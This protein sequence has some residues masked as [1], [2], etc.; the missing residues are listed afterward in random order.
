LRNNLIYEGKNIHFIGIGG[1]GMSG[2][3]HILLQTGCRVSGSDV[4]ESRNTMKLTQEGAIVSIGHS[5]ENIKSAEIVVYSS[6]INASNCELMAARDKD[7]FVISRGEMLAELA[8]N[9]SSIVVAGTHGKTTTTS[10]ISLIFEYN[11]INPTFLIGGELNDIGSNA[12]FGD[13]KYFIAEVDESDGSLLYMES[14]TAVITNIELDHLDYYKNYNDIENVFL[15]FA[16]KVSLN[17][18][19]IICGDFDNLKKIREKFKVINRKIKT[20]GLNVNN[21]IYAS[22]IKLGSFGSVFDVYADNLMKGTV[23]LKVYGIH[24]IHNALAAISVGM[25]YG[26][27]FE[28]IVSVLK[29]FTGVKRRFQYKGTVGEADFIDDYAHHPT[30]VKVTLKGARTGNWKRIVTIFQPHRYSRVKYLY[31]DFGDA[32]NDSDLT[33]ITDIYPAGEDPVPGVS[34]KLIVD[35]ILRKNPRKQ[36]VYLPRK[37]LIKNLLSDILKKGDLV[38]TMGAGDISVI[39]DEALGYLK[40]GLKV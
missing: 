32:F 30:E 13:S 9:K 37:N 3:A 21:D 7:V 19:I 40:S 11:N 2:I 20:Y 23:A 15:E 17:G 14:E 35:S 16:K 6:A 24:N 29:Q 8:R 10:M 25:S 34:G 31:D 22:N 12:K 36:V 1:A 39:G 33:I 28:K 26:I 5:P 27:S 38:L 4:K 18:Q